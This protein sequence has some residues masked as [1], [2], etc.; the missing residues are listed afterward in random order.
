MKKIIFIGLGGIGDL[1]I[2]S[3]TIIEI[4]KKYPDAEKHLLVFKGAHKEVF[5]DAC[6]L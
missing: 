5:K 2:A 6:G 1:I 4:A 3:P